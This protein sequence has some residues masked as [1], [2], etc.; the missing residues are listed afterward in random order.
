VSRADDEKAIAEWLATNQPKA[1]P[2]RV[3]APA[4]SKHVKRRR[5][6]KAPKIEGR[7]IE[8]AVLGKNVAPSEATEPKIIKQLNRR[9][10]NWLGT[11]DPLRE[12]ERKKAERAERQAE[13]QARTNPKLVAGYRRA[14]MRAH[15]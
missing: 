13:R 11:N 5:G 9:A 10:T 15:T 3:A 2:A 4:L 6:R 7:P 14:V 8:S 12:A 1:L